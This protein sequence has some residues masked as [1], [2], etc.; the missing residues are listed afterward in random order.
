[1]LT[2][3]RF[4]PRFEIIDNK[5]NIPKNESILLHCHN[6]YID[7]HGRNLSESITVQC[8][9]DSVFVTET[10]ALDY[11]YIKCHDPVKPTHKNIGVSCSSA[12]STLYMFGYV[13]GSRFQSIYDVCFHLH[14]KTPIH[15]KFTLHKSMANVIPSMDYDKDD[16]M[17]FDFK[18]LYD[19]N[20]QK[21]DL[22]NLT[23][24]DISRKGGCF[25]K[26]QMVNPREV[27][28]GIQG[29]TFSYLNVAPQW[30]LYR[31][32][33]ILCLLE[34]NKLFNYNVL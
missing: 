3:T 18:S 19:C 31:A 12:P 8:D 30:S 24:I 4:I 21:W 20:K 32:V 16:I 6:S 2:S 5:V 13:V 27:F 15:I 33:C 17:L 28:P 9:K 10:Q 25:V 14:R 1:M 23:S 11:K 34:Y 22:I 7:Y 29:V 26:R